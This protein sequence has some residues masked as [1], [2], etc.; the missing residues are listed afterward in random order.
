MAMAPPGRRSL[1]AHAGAPRRTGGPFRGKS[2]RGLTRAPSGRQLA[3]IGHGRGGAR[4]RKV[5]RHC[6][7]RRVAV[8]REARRGARAAARAGVSRGGRACAHAGRCGGGRRRARG[9]ARGGE[10]DGMR[11]GRQ[12]R[13]ETSPPSPV[14]P[15][16]LGLQL[17]DDQPHHHRWQRQQ[18]RHVL[19]QLRLMLLQV[20]LHGHYEVFQQATNR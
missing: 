18:L 20:M 4:A 8:G 15:H 13:G 12:G 7:V 1:A 11:W 17:V 10:R 6:G 5:C 3:R 9:R 14:S 19:Q 16:L 2:G